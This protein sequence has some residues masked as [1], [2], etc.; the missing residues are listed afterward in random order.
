MS[1]SESNDSEIQKLLQNIR[2]K[3]SQGEYVYRGEPE[4][5]DKV[6]S[7]LYRKYAEDIQAE[8]FDIQIA[9]KEM[10]EQVKAYTD[11]TDETDVLTELQH[12]GGKTNL[13]DF[14]TDYLIALF[15]ACDDSPNQDG[16]VILLNRES[17]QGKITSPKKNLNNRVISQK[18]IFF[19]SP[20]GYLD[21]EDSAV[22]IIS[23]PKEMK[24][25][26]LHYLRKYHG[27]ARHTIYNDIL[28]YIQNQKKHQGTYTEFYIGLTFQE[29]GE[30]EEAIKHY[31]QAIR[32]NSQ[33]AE[34]YNN[35]GNAKDLL[36]RHEEAIADYDEA[37]RI[38]P[39]IAQAYYNRGKTKDVLGRH[40]EAIA[41]YNEAIHINPQ[42]AQAYYNRGN[43]KGEL[44]R[45]EEAIADY[46]Q[47]IRID[48]QSAQAYCN[49][50]TA[51]ALLGRHGEAIADYNEAIHINP[52][53]AQAYYGRGIA[54]GMLCRYEE[55]IADYN[56][57]IR[58][59]P[60]FAEAYC[61]RGTA[62]AVL[63]RHGEAIAD[64]NEAI[65]INPQFAEAYCNRGNA[66]KE[67]REY[68]KA[69]ADLQH[70]L[71]LATEQNDQTLAQNAQRLLDQ[72]PPAG[73]ED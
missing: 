45:H 56:E 68:K 67:I 31:D 29:K 28:G 1:K 63:G 42:F 32:I 9:Q 52:Q 73:E 41:D 21:E 7:T 5:Y 2:G 14:T 70:A 13:I 23:I 19:Q 50:G 66:N 51:K 59:N 20:K 15:F 47:A 30:Y 60:Q 44:D 43:A 62:K 3:T 39:Q 38:N 16:R 35:R 4:K 49:R 10:L 17:N 58:I 33:F 11:F 37:I 72:L 46:D 27:I 71:E 36:G 8:K 12:Y 55:A 69:R 64:Y 65:R 61:D 26:V 24:Q 54:K 57:T 48:P 25:P 18:S 40:K 53:F 6:S 34:A 22:E